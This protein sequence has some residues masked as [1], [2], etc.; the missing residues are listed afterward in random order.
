VTPTTLEGWRYFLLLVD[1]DARI[2]HKTHVP[3]SDTVS[4]TDTPRILPDMY[5]RRI[6]YFC[7]FK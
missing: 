7:I 6:G 1:Y 5:R 4:D 3:V 2:L